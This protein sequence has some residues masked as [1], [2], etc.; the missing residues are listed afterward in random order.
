[1]AKQGQEMWAKRCAHIKKRQ[2]YSNLDFGYAK[3]WAINYSIIVENE[4]CKKN[5]NQNYTISTRS[6]KE[7][8]VVLVQTSTP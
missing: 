3:S 6:T 8:L 5:S 4:S 1:M 7:R 2:S